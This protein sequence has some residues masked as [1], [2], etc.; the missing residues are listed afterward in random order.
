MTKD[1]EIT[2]ELKREQGSFLEQLDYLRALSSYIEKKVAEKLALVPEDPYESVDTKDINASL[3][4]AQGDFDSAGFNRRNPHWNSKYADLDIIVKTIR[5]SLAKN[6]LSITQQTILSDT[7][8]TILVTKVRHISGQ[9]IGTKARIIPTKADAQSYGSSLTYM[10]RY[11][12]C[13]LLNITTADDVLDDDAESI[14]PN[15]RDKKDKGVTINSKYN[16][17]LESFETISK[18]QLD[19]IEFEIAEHDDIAE[20]VLDGLKIQTLADMPKNRYSYSIRRVR[21]LKIAREGLD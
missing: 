3:S 7:G 6:N 13:A 20:Q 21:E 4:K 11:S 17:R 1:K 15:V 5:P 8:S 19:E 18:D 12:L 10:K 14:M 16:P 2:M 9:W